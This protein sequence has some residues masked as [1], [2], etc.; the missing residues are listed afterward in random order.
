M[1]AMP[2][3]HANGSGWLPT[4]SDITFFLES[5]IINGSYV[6]LRNDLLASEHRHD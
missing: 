5:M 4:A 1:G 6:K 3:R 2:E